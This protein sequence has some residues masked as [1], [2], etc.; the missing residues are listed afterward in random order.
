M[1]NHES[2]EITPDHLVVG[3]DERMR[4]VLE[5]RELVR[6][7]RYKLDPAAVAAA[8]LE[9]WRRSS[10]RDEPPVEDGLSRFVVYPNDGPAQTGENGAE[11]SA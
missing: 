11:R 4:R 3:F 10:A 5:L 8:M 2:T 7:G 6:Q 9:E 1:P